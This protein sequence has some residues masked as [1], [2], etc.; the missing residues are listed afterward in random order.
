M[1]G[2]ISVSYRYDAEKKTIHLFAFSRTLCG[3]HLRLPQVPDEQ[4]VKLYSRC[5]KCERTFQKTIN[6]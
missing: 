3:K 6:L 5:G 2:Q 1:S 4:Q